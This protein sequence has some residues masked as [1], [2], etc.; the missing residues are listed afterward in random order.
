MSDGRVEITIAAVNNFEE[1][2]TT[3]AGGLLKEYQY[4]RAR[5]TANAA[6]IEPFKEASEAGETVANEASH[7]KKKTVVEAGDQAEDTVVPINIKFETTTEEEPAQDISKEAVEHI[8]ASEETDEAAPPASSDQ[9]SWHQCGGS[10][11]QARPEPGGW[12]GAPTFAS[13]T[14][15]HRYERLR[16]RHGPGLM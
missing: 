14:F 6:S 4:E 2:V 11:G 12:S 15:L 1:D 8:K 10:Q 13:T 9:H 16:G 7:K 5:P 3:A